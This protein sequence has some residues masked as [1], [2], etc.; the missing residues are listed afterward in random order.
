MAF[1][2]L[3]LSQLAHI[4]AV[5]S[6]HESLFTQ[7]LLSNVPLLAATV[8][9]LALQMATL[10]VPVFTRVFKT[11]PLTARELLSCIGLASAVFLAVELEKAVRRR[12]KAGAS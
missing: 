4:L 8:L 5:R 3:T 9:T 6:E 1:T 2:V 12:T 7:G 11:T 10:Y